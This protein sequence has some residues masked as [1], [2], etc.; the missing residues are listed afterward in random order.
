MQQ[1]REGVKSLVIS[2][3]QKVIEIQREK[4]IQPGHISGI[5]TMQLP[6]RYHEGKFNPQGLEVAGTNQSWIPP[7]SCEQRHLRLWK[8]WQG[9][10]R[11]TSETESMMS[12]SAFTIFFLPP[13]R[14]SH[15]K[16]SPS[17]ICYFEVLTFLYLQQR[18]NCK[19]QAPSNIQITSRQHKHPSVPTASGR[20]ISGLFQNICHSV[21]GTW[22]EVQVDVEVN[23]GGCLVSFALQS[24]YHLAT[25]TPCSKIQ[26]FE[27]PGSLV[28]CYRAAHSMQ[29]RPAEESRGSMTHKAEKS[30]LPSRLIC[31]CK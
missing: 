29:G 15:V 11:N 17:Q 13:L 16:T 1:F 27:K 22:C 31:I 28:L 10:I 3:R 2:E 30:T 4:Q 24:S 14:V 12:H 20:F 7:T 19:W 8:L 5:S 21:V 26:A 25:L 6:A 18:L 9:H 23:F